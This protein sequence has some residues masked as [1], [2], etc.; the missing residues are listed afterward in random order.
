MK[1][2][3]RPKALS[4]RSFPPLAALLLLDVGPRYACVGAPGQRREI[5]AGYLC[6]MKVDGP[7]AELAAPTVT[8]LRLE[9]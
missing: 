6:Q 5:L 9:G 1:A 4:A 2:K 3:A 8:T 7:L